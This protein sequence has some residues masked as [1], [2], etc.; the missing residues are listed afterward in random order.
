LV[1]DIKVRKEP[2]YTV[3][4]LTHVGRHTGEN[5][6]R[7]EF[8]D[9]VRWATKR[10]L[11]TGKWFFYELDGPET[12]E[13][14]RRWEACVEINRKVKTGG[15]FGVKK[16]PAQTMACVRF[17]PDEVSANLVYHGIQGWLEWR[18]KNGG[19]EDGG[20]WRETYPD[21]PWTNA[22]AWAR[23]EVQAPINKVKKKR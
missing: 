7:Q 1:V 10:K 2:S 21:N 20:T 12:A 8:E 5:M 16:L 19:Y 15:R 13:K 18:K 11:R 4:Y 22:K 9:L 17:N 3:A 6:L 23:T 14:T